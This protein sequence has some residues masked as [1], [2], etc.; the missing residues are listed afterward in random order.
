LLSEEAKLIENTSGTLEELSSL[1]LQL[2]TALTGY[3]AVYEMDLYHDMNEMDLLQNLKNNAA[4]YM[5]YKLNKQQVNQLQEQTN[6]ALMELREFLRGFQFDNMEELLQ[7]KLNT[8]LLNRNQYMDLSKKVESLQESIR[9]FEAE[10]D[11]SEDMESVEEVQQ[12]QTEIDDKIAE[13]NQFIAK[14]RE[15]L[16]VLT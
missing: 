16:T 12:R 9:E 7:N 13:C 1:Q 14:E 4:T 10:H 5:E 15:E 3:A 2:Y 11:L 8:V 6:Q